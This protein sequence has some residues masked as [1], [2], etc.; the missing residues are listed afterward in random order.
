MIRG[1]HTPSL[2]SKQNPWKMLVH[3]CHMCVCLGVAIHDDLCPH[4][5]FVNP[6]V[7]EISMAWIL[8]DILLT[9]P[10]WKKNMLRVVF[11]TNAV[12]NRIAGLNSC[13]KELCRYILS[14]VVS[15]LLK[16]QKKSENWKTQPQM[17]LLHI[18]FGTRYVPLVFNQTASKTIPVKNPKILWEF[19]T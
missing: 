2:G 19:N 6:S 12:S 10:S 15:G 14:I 4:N 18:V 7:P 8:D 11:S 17:F 9:Q 5:R 13:W 3:I 16:L 1:A